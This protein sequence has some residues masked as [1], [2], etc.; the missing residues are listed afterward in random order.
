MLVNRIVEGIVNGQA[1]ITGEGDSA[2]LM[3][4]LSK[5]LLDDFFK[6]PKII[7]KPSQAK[8]NIFLFDKKEKL[9]LST[10]HDLLVIRETSLLQELAL[11]FKDKNSNPF[12]IF[13][14]Q[15]SEI[16]QEIALCHG[17]RTCFDICLSK[18]GKK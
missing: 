8:D 16:V 3:Q 9:D 10:I 5:D 13:M 6:N 11:T 7:P 4:K 15:E 18:I 17:E 14:K 1:G 2:V 12:N